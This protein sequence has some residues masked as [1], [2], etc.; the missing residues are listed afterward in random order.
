MYFLPFPVVLRVLVL[1]SVM[2]LSLLAMRPASAGESRFMACVA[3]LKQSARNAG[4]PADVIDDVLGQVSFNARVVELD[5]QQPEFTQTLAG[6]FGTR[7]TERRVAQGRRLMAEHRD[8]LAQVQRN[9]GVAPQYIIA[10][11]GLET[12]FGS[13]FGRMEVPEALATLA[14]DERRPEYFT[15][16]LLA[17]LRIIAAGDVVPERMQGSWAGAMGH[18]QFMPSVFLQYAVDADGNGRRDIWNSVPDALASAGNLLHHVGWVAGQRWGREVRLPPG[19]AFELAGRDRRL[20][21]SRWAELGVMM[22]SGAPLP[23]VDIDASL[24]LPEGHRG[25]AFLVYDNFSVIMRWNRSELF[26]LAVGHLADR[27]AGAGPLAVAPLADLRPL[28]RDE[29]RALQ[30]ALNAR[31]FEAGEPDGIFGPATRQAVSRFQ[32][33]ENLVADGFPD[34]T[35]VRK[36]VQ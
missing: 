8:L 5:R 19:F 31:G 16:E 36:L 1:A 34:D 3:G 26:A 7:V 24:L 12:S 18:V 29:V 20:P 33:A 9:T 17:A 28:S 13:N 27:I 2:S 22:T 10:L 32:L 6:Y 30:T 25:P 23:A 14:C 4:I 15:S 35:V 21:L 11:W